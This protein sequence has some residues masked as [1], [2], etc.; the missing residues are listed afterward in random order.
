MIRLLFLTVF[1]ILADESIAASCVKT[2]SVC[3]DTT[4]CKT[5]SGVSV[6]LTDPGINSTCWQ[7]SDTYKCIKPNAIDYCA[8]ISQTPGCTQLS[9]T[10][11]VTDTLFGAGCMTWTNTWRCGAGLATPANTTM[12]NTSYTIASNAL[13]TSLCATYASNPTCSIASHVC[14]DTTPSKVI[15]GLSVTLAQAGGCWSYTDSYSCLGTMQSN[16]ATL[17]AK[18]CTLDTSKCIKYGLGSTCTLTEN[19]YRCQSTPGTSS[20]GVN[21]GSNQYCTGGNCFNAGHVPDADMTQ[22]AAMMEGM[23]QAGNYMNGMA[24]FGGTNGSCTANPLN[25]CC[26]P[27]GGASNNGSILGNALM[28]A[29]GQVLKYGSSYVYDTL[30][31]NYHIV[32]GLDSMLSSTPFGGLVGGS[33]AGFSPSFGLYGFTA[34]FGAAPAG[35]TVLGS[36]GGFTFAFDPTSLAISVAI[37]VVTEMMSCT[38]DEKILSMKLGQN[39]CRFTGSYCSMEIPIVGGCIETTQTYCCFN[40]RLARIINTAGGLQLGR[41]VTDCTGFTPDQFALLDFS[42]IDLSEFTA[43]IMANVHLPSTTAIGIDSTNT[44]QYKLNNYYTRGRQ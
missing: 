19:V 24:I 8:A 37:M 29:G 44:M 26:K 3:A 11:A 13:N 41:A 35:A 23:R 30:Y 1:L 34:T 2:G 4:P 40:S 9:L 16:C 6:C 7:Y 28:S 36:A 32:R 39:L 20:T 5:I 27:S 43:E 42:K 38:P 33:S 21:C 12:L 14:S 17:Q 18:G 10:C 15:N 22:A 25:S 31:D